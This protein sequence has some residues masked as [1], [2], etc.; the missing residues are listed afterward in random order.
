MLHG[1]LD[2]KEAGGERIHGYVCMAESL[3][4]SPETITTV[5]ISYAPTQNKVLK[6]REERTKGEKRKHKV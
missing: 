1:S 4:F 6:K 2:G 3:P 5:F